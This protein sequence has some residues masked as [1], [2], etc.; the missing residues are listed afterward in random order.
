MTTA[1]II[2]IVDTNIFIYAYIGGDLTKSMLSRRLLD[3][4]VAN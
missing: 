2:Y 4:L 3:D 1:S